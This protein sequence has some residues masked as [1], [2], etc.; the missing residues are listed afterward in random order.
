MNL[1]I[2]IENGNPVNHP[3]FEDN[4]IQVFGSVPDNW[5]PFLRVTPLNPDVY[6]V[7]E[8]VYSKVDDMW[9]DIY[10]LRSMTA[11]EIADKQQAVRAEWA[12]QPDA[13]NFTTWVL[14]EE[15]CSMI[16]P[17]PIPDEAGKVFQWSGSENNW[18]EV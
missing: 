5:E 15:T 4:L 18:I 1:Y 17:I 6:E 3:A 13:S 12:S 16:P 11:E 10:T 7:L 2:Q 8:N 9:T 14:D